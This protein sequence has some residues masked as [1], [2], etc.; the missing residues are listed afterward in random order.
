[1]R[2][3]KNGL[4]K[5]VLLVVV[6]AVFSGTIMQWVKKIPLIGDSLGDMH[7]KNDKK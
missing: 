1:M 2:R 6:G 4:I 7:D 5:T 3:K